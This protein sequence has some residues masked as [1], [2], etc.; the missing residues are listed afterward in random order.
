MYVIFFIFGKKNT[1]KRRKVLMS[2]WAGETSGKDQSFGRYSLDQ[3]CGGDWY[4]VPLQMAYR[5][6]HKTTA[7]N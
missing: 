4:K 7:E 2:K 6:D 5:C 3:K 1:S